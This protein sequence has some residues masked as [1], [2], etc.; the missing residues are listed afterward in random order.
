[1]NANDNLP[2]PD[3]E[4]GRRLIDSDLM[5]L[6]KVLQCN[7]KRLVNHS[8][9]HGWVCRMRCVKLVLKVTMVCCIACPTDLLFSEDDYPLTIPR[10][11][12]TTIDLAIDLEPLFNTHS[13][14]NS[15]AQRHGEADARPAST[16]ELTLTGTLLAGNHRRAWIAIP[17]QGVHE[18]GIGQHLPGTPLQVS[19]IFSESVILVDREVCKTGINCTAKITLEMHH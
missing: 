18:L 1:M 19:R 17:G 14:Q 13:R 15:G 12:S 16:P 2:K 5:A 7:F 6:C 9:L 11:K 8:Q 10:I 3:A 4:S